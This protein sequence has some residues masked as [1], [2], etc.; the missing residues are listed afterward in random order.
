MGQY[1][2]AV[3]E[4]KQNKFIKKVKEYNQKYS[5]MKKKQKQTQIKRK[6]SEYNSI[7]EEN[8]F[9]IAQV[10]NKKLKEQLAKPSKYKKEEKGFGFSLE[11]GIPELSIFSKKKKR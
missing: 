5:D 10:K 4:S 3:K 11:S 9:L 2:K 7:K 8:N 6:V 1:K